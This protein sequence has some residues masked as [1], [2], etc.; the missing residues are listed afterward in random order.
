M[1]IKLSKIFS[2]LKYYISIKPDKLAYFIITIP[3]L[4]REALK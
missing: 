1:Q 3:K 2:F 4:V